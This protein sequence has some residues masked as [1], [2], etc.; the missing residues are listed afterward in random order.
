MASEAPQQTNEERAL[1]VVESSIANYSDEFKRLLGNSVD[2]EMF[3]SV[4]YEAYRSNRDLLNIALTSPDSLMK[5]LHDAA[6]LKLVPNGVL[7]GAYIVPRQNRQTGR[8]EAYFQV[9][10]RG[11]IELVMRSGH[12]SKC[13]ARV[14]HEKDD[15]ALRYGTEPG[16]DHVPYIDGDPGKVRGAYFVAFLRDGSQLVEY[17]SAEQINAI[18]ER[19]PAK[20]SGP[21]VT[22]YEEMCRKTVARRG[23]KYLPMSVE[24][25]RAI[26]FDDAGETAEPVAATV[27]EPEPPAASLA[28]R[29]RQTMAQAEGPKNVTPAPDEQP[30]SSPPTQPVT[31]P[32]PE[33]SEPAQEPTEPPVK[34]AT[35][36]RKKKVAEPEPEPQEAP[37]EAS[38]DVPDDLPEDEPA[39]DEPAASPSKQFGSAESAPRDAEPF[40]GIVYAKGESIRLKSDAG[41]T[42]KLIADDEQVSAFFESITGDGGPAFRADGY[43]VRELVAWQNAQAVSMPPYRQFTVYALTI[44]ESVDRP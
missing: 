29:I 38:F 35:R 2:P 28:G 24:I 5:A 41:W 37:E 1:A 32:E 15:F 44:G 31:T 12:V 40:S 11:L 34:P 23:V 18:R 10:Y 16:V 36:S 19:S 7:G 21:W 4:A 20:N 17:M 8:R 22:D 26:E 25:Q 33:T 6:A 30:S 14:V 9:G 13:E 43:G 3:M 27:S 42:G 39:D